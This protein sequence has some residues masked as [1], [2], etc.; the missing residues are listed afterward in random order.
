MLFQDLMSYCWDIYKNGANPKI[1]AGFSD[2]I[3]D[4]KSGLFACLL[5]FNFQREKE[6]EAGFAS[7]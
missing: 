4:E 2:V 1:W 7:A 5:E 3:D 6:Q